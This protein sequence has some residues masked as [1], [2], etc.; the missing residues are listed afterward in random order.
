MAKRDDGPHGP[1]LQPVRGGAPHI[2]LSEEEI[3]EIRG[4]EGALKDLLKRASTAL[5]ISLAVIHLPDKQITIR[6]DSNDWPLPNAGRVVRNLQRSLAE[7]TKSAASK[8]QLALEVSVS[9]TN[10]SAAIVS[11]GDNFEGVLFVARGSGGNEFSPREQNLLNA[12]ACNIGEIIAARFDPLTGLMN[13]REFDSVLDRTISDRKGREISHSLLH[14]N[15]DHLKSVE[16]SFG[17][18]AADAA[19]CAAAATLRSVPAPS[20]T[21]AYLGNDEFGVFLRDCPAD[22]GIHACDGSAL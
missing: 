7:R 21:L 10:Y 22:R 16:D 9:C 2:C 15:L 19:I 18:A 3:G 5:S 20:M 8:E 11:E 17:S 4:V 6:V 13:Q 14:V 12:I 1:G